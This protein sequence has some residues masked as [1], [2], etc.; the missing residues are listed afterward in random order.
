ML[1]H[2]GSGTDYSAPPHRK[3]VKHD[4]AHPDQHVVFD[5]AVA[6]DRRR[7][8]HADEVPESRVVP[9]RRV[10]IEVHV[11]P[12]SDVRGYPRPGA[13]DRAGAD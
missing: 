11:T 1:D 10:R 6:R 7:R 12:K 2:T 8:V 9:D 13:D 4:G 3:L 5:D